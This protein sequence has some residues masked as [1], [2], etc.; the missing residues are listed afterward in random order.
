MAAL[1][2][3]QVD[4]EDE[5]LLDYYSIWVDPYGYAICDKMDLSQMI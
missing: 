5:W 1:N 4:K 3:I 2:N